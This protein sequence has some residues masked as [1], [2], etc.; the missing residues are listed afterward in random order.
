MPQALRNPMVWAA[1][2]LIAVA[3]G[4]LVI[5]STDDQPELFDSATLSATISDLGDDADGRIID[6]R[7]S[8]VGDLGDA[9]VLT[10]LSGIPVFDE[11]DRC[12]WLV[13]VPGTDSGI[14]YLVAWP[15][16]T[17]ILWDPF[18]VQLPEPS[19]NDVLV[20]GD[21]ISG[22]GEI[23]GDRAELAD[24]DQAR[25]LG[26]ENCPHEAVLVFDDVPGTTTVTRSGG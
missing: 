9:A 6:E 16:G 21:R 23:Y 10:E 15:T 25:L 11:R 14:R 17:E 12:A 4:V 2:V 7:T 8:T 22:T 19:P 20:A 13:G 1:A 3:I 5:G 24:R 26:L 18:R